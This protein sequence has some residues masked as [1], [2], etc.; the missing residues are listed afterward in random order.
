LARTQFYKTVF[1]SKH[2]YASAIEEH[3][4]KQV[5]KQ[6]LVDFYNKYYNFSKLSIIVSGKVETQHFDILNKYFGKQTIIK[7]NDSL[8]IDYTTDYKPSQNIF[9]EKKDAVQASIK[10]G[11]ISINKNHSDFIKLSVTNT[12]LGG[13]FGSRLMANIREDKGYTYGIYSA[14]VSQLHSGLFVIAAET[15]KE[16]YQKAIDEVFKEL[17]IFRTTL[18]KN[19]ELQRVRNYLTGQLASSFDGPFSL[20]SAFQSLLEYD[21]DYTFFDNY[22]NTIKN[23]KAE[24][25]RDI[26]QKYL[27][28]E[29][30]SVITSCSK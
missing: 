1:G 28:E 11:Q 4:Y 12:F 8:N 18:V 19:E 21:L 23:I 7:T 27:N 2:I 14:N 20:S 30:M 9:I 25:I 17:K 16:V 5:N 22:F 26:A 10:I 24:E 3:H 13:Y 29:T 15:G 6:Q